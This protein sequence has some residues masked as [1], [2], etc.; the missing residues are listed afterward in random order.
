[1]D[2]QTEMTVQSLASTSKQYKDNALMAK[3]VA[4]FLSEQNASLYWKSAAAE[5]FK[6]KM[7]QYMDAQNATLSTSRG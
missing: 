4:S 3:N 5:R 6:A 7:Q 1:M 2:R